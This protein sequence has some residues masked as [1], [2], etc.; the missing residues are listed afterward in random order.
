[1]ITAESTADL[2]PALCERYGIRIIPMLIQL[3]DASFPDDGNF[4]PAD[5]YAR[6][7]KDGTLPK[8]AT[9]GLQ[10]FLDFFS[11]FTRDFMMSSFSQC[12]PMMQS[13]RASR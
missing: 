1:M 10:I 12:I 7:Q 2:P 8:T 13:S 11:S 4:T 9:P 3:G 5:L 6:F